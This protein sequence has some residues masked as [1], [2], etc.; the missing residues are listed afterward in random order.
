MATIAIIYGQSL[1]FGFLAHDDTSFVSGNPLVA[2]GLSVAGVA[3]AF[4]S[5]PMG[6]WHPL[7]VISHML[8]CQIFGLDAR[9]HHLTNLVLHAATSIGLFLVLRSMTGEMW[10][11]ALVATLLAIHPQHVESVAWISERRDVLSG[12]FFVL[13]LA[14]YLGYVRHGRTLGR[15]LLLALVFAL[16]LMSKATLVT[17][18]LLLLL[19]DYW[20]LAR[21]GS[22]AGGREPAERKSLWWLAVEKLPLLALSVADCVLTVVTQNASDTV[23]ERHLTERLGTALVAPVE[24]LRLAFWPAGLAGFYPI[25]VG[26]FPA[27]RVVCSLAL[28]TAVTIAVVVWRRRSPYLLVGWF[29]FLGTLVPMLGLI[30]IAEHAMAD[31]YMY[32]PQIG[33][34]IAVAWGAARLA[35]NSEARRYTLAMCSGLAIVLLA[36]CAVVQTT[37]WHDDQK[38]WAHS[39]EVTGSNFHVEVALADALHHA[40]RLDEAVE[41]YHRA[42]DW[43]SSSKLMN[44]LGIALARQKKLTEAIPYFRRAIELDLLAAGPRANL[45]QA[46]GAQGHADEAIEQY[47]S[48]IELD[49][50]VGLWHFNVAGLL[51][52]QGRL[53]DAIAH[54]RQTIELDPTRAIVHAELAAL[55]VRGDRI[56]EAI[57]QYRRAVEL[58]PRDTRLRQALDQVVAI[59]RSKSGLPKPEN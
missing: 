25:P 21:F 52:R 29:W 44:N 1:W 36:S 57:D 4:V 43:G 56:D 23:N 34:S 22:P 19:L 46:L 15:Y 32:L 54:L 35:A 51:A 5:G 3:A 11:S 18:P 2:P 27:W 13:T 38:L 20:P 26:G 48:A 8:D 50:N 17:V 9:G 10:P 14:A 58:E 28:L 24:Y 49:P 59:R 7:S 33:L 47:L 42:L 6:Q 39:L 30:T 55:L 45:A 16:G 41:H 37:H 40:G 53:D 12:L 31:R